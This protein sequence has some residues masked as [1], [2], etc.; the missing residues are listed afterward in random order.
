LDTALA[1][2]Q[3]GINNE[4]IAS[5]LRAALDALGEITG[6][7]DHERVLDHIFSAFCIGK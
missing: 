7:I 3:A 2:L 5:D 6:R 1:G 4:L